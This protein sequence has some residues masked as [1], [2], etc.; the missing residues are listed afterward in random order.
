MSRPAH[1]AEPALL[2][3][4]AGHGRGDAARRNGELT[5]QEDGTRMI[6]VL[7]ILADLVVGIAVAIVLNRI[8]PTR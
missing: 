8:D 5:T 7:V 1:L 3:G 2:K 4:R 6:P